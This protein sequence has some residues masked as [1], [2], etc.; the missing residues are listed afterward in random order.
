MIISIII[1]KFEN[2]RRSSHYK[3]FIN[4]HHHSKEH[5]YMSCYMKI[6][7]TRKKH[8]W[9]FSTSTF[10]KKEKFTD[11]YNAAS[12]HIEY[13]I[14][15]WRLIYLDDDF[16]SNYMTFFYHLRYFP[17]DIIRSFMCCVSI[18][19]N[20]V[21]VF[22]ICHEEILQAYSEFW[23]GSQKPFQKVDTW[24][25]YT[26]NMN[27]SVRSVAFLHSFLIVLLVC[28]HSLITTIKCYSCSVTGEETFMLWSPL[29][30]I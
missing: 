6:Y 7:W 28:I 17:G 20:L 14:E 4:R 1:V 27:Y 24:G 23:E 21:S 22:G 15:C 12:S 10:I 8:S 2:E 9:T 11:T 5:F 26:E 19:I 25:W 29:P 13:W 16:Y 18:H 3:S 30:V